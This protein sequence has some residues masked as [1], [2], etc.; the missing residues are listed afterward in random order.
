MSNS[1]T[2]NTTSSPYHFEDATQLQTELDCPKCGLRSP[3]GDELLHLRHQVITDPLTG[4]FNVRHFRASLE[5]EIERTARTRIPTSLMMVDLDHFK[6]VNDVWGHETGNRVLKMV[7]RLITQATRQLDIQCRYGGEEFAII[8]PTT[9]ILLATQVAERLRLLIENS[10]IEVD[11]KILKVTASIG[12][13]ECSE[14]EQ[15]TAGALVEATDAM[16]YQAKEQGRNQVCFTAKSLQEES[17]VSN[18]ERDALSGL[19]AN[20][21]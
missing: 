21:D 15:Y 18:E 6:Q 3:W 5:L 10:E 11:Q 8:L 12:L 14:P 4:L 2:L 20:D 13:S 19:F 16:L 17:A 7:S 1:S 9:G